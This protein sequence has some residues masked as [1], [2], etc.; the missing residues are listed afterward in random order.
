MKDLINIFNYQQFLDTLDSHYLVLDTKGVILAYNEALKQFVLKDVNN[1]YPELNG[2]VAGM[3]YEDLVLTGNW[4]NII[5]NERMKK[6][7][8]CIEERSKKR[9]VD[10]NRNE[11][12]EGLITPIFDDNGNVRYVTVNIEVVTGKK[13][14]ELKKNLSFFS[15]KEIQ[16]LKEI[17]NQKTELEI[18]TNT[19]SFIDF[20]NLHLTESSK[21]IIDRALMSD[22]GFFNRSEYLKRVNNKL[23]KRH[24]NLNEF[25]L[26]LKFTISRLPDKS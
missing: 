21:R 26:C 8:E 5:V 16:F 3:T 14:F 2:N 9:F 4:G 11:I 10:V 7:N 17:V 15:L 13:I 6:F 24:I 20:Y 25:L 12:L 19:D 23:Q 18:F 1:K 22:S